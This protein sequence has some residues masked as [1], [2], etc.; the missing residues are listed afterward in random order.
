MY[1]GSEV[2]SMGCCSAATKDSA[3]RGQAVLWGLRAVFADVDPGLLAEGSVRR[4]FFENP[5]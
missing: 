2:W 3:A 4:T 1:D 5:K